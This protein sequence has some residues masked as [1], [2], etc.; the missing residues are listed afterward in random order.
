MANW[1]KVEN[2]IP[3]VGDIATHTS[4]KLDPRKVARVEAGDVWLEL[5]S[6]TSL[7]GPF[8]ASSYTFE[9]K[10]QD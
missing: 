2:G 10:V 5:S 4:G 9:R 3:Q 7:M 1:Q 6:P 8:P